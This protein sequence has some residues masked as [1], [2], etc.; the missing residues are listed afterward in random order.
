MYVYDISN[1]IFVLYMQLDV[2]RSIHWAFVLKMELNLIEYKKVKREA[3]LPYLNL[4]RPGYS[5]TLVIET[6]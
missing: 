6:P 3:K 2:F 5:P 1:I 4:F